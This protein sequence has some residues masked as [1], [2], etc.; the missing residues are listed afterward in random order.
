MSF[1]CCPAKR[2]SDDHGHRREAILQPRMES[3]ASLCILIPRLVLALHMEWCEIRLEFHQRR[4][5]Q[6]W[7]NGMQAW[8]NQSSVSTHL[9]LISP[10]G[11]KIEW[12]E[13]EQ[14][15]GLSI[16]DVR[17]ILRF[18]DPSS[19]PLSQ[20]AITKLTRTIVTS[21]CTPSPFSARTSFKYRP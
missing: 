1:Q 11:G 13:S 21:W 19:L 4:A 15:K 17:K 18:F 10:N 6:L 7:N 8:M 5:W 20:I 12:V 2:A 14:G 3:S 9:L 16:N